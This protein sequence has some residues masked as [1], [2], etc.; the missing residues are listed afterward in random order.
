VKTHC[1][2]CAGSSGRVGGKEGCLETSEGDLDRPKVVVVEQRVMVVG[3]EGH[4]HTVALDI[5]SQA[6]AQ[7]V[8][9]RRVAY[10]GVL[11]GEEARRNSWDCGC[12]SRTLPWTM[13]GS[14]GREKLDIAKVSVMEV[15]GIGMG[16]IGLE[17][18]AGLGAHTGS[19]GRR[20]EPGFVAEG[21]R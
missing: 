4:P 17:E 18:R 5:R 13:Y 8:M 11:A 1:S 3:V 21:A 15:Q 14:V 12:Q 6:V 7:A 20:L 19:G 9:K 10:Q 2:H 16:Y